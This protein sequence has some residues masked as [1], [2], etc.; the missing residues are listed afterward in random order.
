MP[1]QWCRI[2]RYN[3]DAL[4]L[5]GVFLCYTAEMSTKVVV[6]IRLWRMLRLIAH[7]LWGVILTSW[8]FPRYCREQ[9]VLATQRWS[10]SLLRMAQIRLRVI[11]KPDRLYP[12]NTL[13]VAN[14]VSWLDIFVMNAAVVSRFVAKSEI[15]DWPVIGRMV[16]NGG[17]LFIEREKRRDTARVTKAI[18][19][20][21]KDGDCLAFFPEGTTADG[22]A[23]KPFKSS[24]FQP[25]IEAGADVLPVALR[26][27][28]ASGKVLLAASY[29]GDISLLQC[30]WHIVSEPEIYAELIFG[31]PVNCAGKSRR[32]LCHHAEL[33]IATA[34][35]LPLPGKKP[36][37]PVDLPA[38]VQSDPHPTDSPNPRHKDSH[39]A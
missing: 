15:R 35:S 16:V 12:A 7:L 21:L 11:G 38:L 4:N 39:P 10:A 26:Y 18:S 28:D 20:A 29:A 19:Q 32:E 9:R 30:T 23:L 17:T 13:M 8:L 2:G 37:A 3:G 6:P 25:A 31:L 36:V 33:T 34:L 27:V 1:V 14:H 22:T 24:M 5:R